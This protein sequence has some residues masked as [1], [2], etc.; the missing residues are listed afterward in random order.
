MAYPRK[1]L[2][3]PLARIVTPP[4]R[5]RRRVIRRAMTRA[6][7][8]GR[9]GARLNPYLTAAGMAGSIYSMHRGMRG[10]VMNRRRRI[11]GTK[12]TTPRIQSFYSNNSSV[13]ATAAGTHTLNRK[14]LWSSAI[15]FAR[16]VGTS[17]QINLGAVHGQRIYVKGIRV[18]LRMQNVLGAA[19]PGRNSLHVHFAILQLKLGGGNPIDPLQG[20]GQELS[21]ANF[22]VNPGGG[23]NGNERDI[24]FDNAVDGDPSVN[25]DMRYDCNGINPDRFNI[26]THQRIRLD[27]IDRSDSSRNDTKTI[28]KYVKVNKPFQYENAVDDFVRRPLFLVMWCDRILPNGV[29]PQVEETAIRYSINTVSYFKSIN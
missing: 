2:R 12:T 10:K 26:I 22:F 1:R 11:Y 17:T 27:E 18:C 13:L 24:G 14:T 4:R 15:K 5:V 8:L 6:A 7:I 21:P 3:Y 25:W 28:D 29:T 23:R 9:L 20:T 19:P 16:R